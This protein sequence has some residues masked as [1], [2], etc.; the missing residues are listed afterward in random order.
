ME[1]IGLIETR[2]LVAAMEALDTMCK[3]ATVKMID[4]KVVGSGL[5]AVV[6]EGDVAAVTAAVEAGKTAYE[7]TG[8]ELISCNVIPRP[9][10]E[11]AKILF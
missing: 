4:M 3:A 1:A 10:P 5:V 6:V 2:G 11:L 7:R 9:H 8:G